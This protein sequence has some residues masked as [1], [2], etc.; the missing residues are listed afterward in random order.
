[1]VI[2]YHITYF[3][4]LSMFRL[5]CKPSH[6]NQLKMANKL[7]L[8]YLIGASKLTS[9]LALI[10]AFACLVLVPWSPW[11][12]LVEH[13]CSSFAPVVFCV[14][15][16]S[17]FLFWWCWRGLLVR[18]PNQWGLDTLLG[19]SGLEHWWMAFSSRRLRMS[20]TWEK[21]L[22]QTLIYLLKRLLASSY[23]CILKTWI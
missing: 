23:F 22:P 3:G 10:K 20:W 4:Y 16:R 6:V 9:P 21:S 7:D 17:F 19:S 8:Q 2:D 15:V 1:M 14:Q 5:E 11:I 12:S 18:G 13:S